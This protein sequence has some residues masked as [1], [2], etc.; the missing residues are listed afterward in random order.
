MGTES[1]MV[2]GSPGLS[3]TPTLIL[4]GWG[5]GLK[6]PLHQGVAL[7]PGCW[8]KCPQ[9]AA[10]DSGESQTSALSPPSLPLAAAEPHQ[11]GPQVPGS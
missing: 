5:P 11:E 7:G 4:D 3:A 10:G 9:I 8:G 2:P 1:V 6:A